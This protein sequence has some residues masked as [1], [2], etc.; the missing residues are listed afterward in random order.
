MASEKENPN[1][2]AQLRYG[3]IKT[4]FQHHTVIAEGRAGDLVEG[5]ECRKGPAFMALKTWSNSADEASAMIQDIGAQIG[6]IV[7]GRIE[8]FD[9]AP[10]KAPGEHPYGY[11]INFTPFNEDDE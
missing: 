3:K 6:F 2:I 9:S 10:V 5:F 4:P 8:V 1:L 7:T 11:D